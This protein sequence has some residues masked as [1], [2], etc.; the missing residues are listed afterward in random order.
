MS[1]DAHQHPQQ[2]DEQQPTTGERF[3]FVL[4]ARNCFEFSVVPVA[5]T[6]GMRASPHIYESTV[7]IHH[8]IRVVSHEFG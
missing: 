6:P 1:T 7:H 5:G 4:E 3:G 2:P 8:R